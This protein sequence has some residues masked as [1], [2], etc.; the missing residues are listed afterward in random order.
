M[1]NIFKRKEERQNTPHEITMEER[2][3]EWDRKIER[4]NYKAR[5]EDREAER[6]EPIV[7]YKNT[8]SKQIRTPSED[9]R[10]AARRKKIKERD[11]QLLRELRETEQAGVD[12]LK[13]GGKVA[14]VMVKDVAA[15]GKVA[16]KGLSDWA[17]RMA[18]E[19]PKKKRA[20]PTTPKRKN[21][22]RTVKTV[23][24]TNKRTRT[25]T[26]KP[27]TVTKRKVVKKRKVTKRDN[28]IFW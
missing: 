25:S 20:K 8:P 26:R 9:E 15:A 6:N 21:V 28:D 27:V 10:I 19:P 3:R 14:K 1:F 7:Y 23:K 2:Q 17:D 18:E 5:E 22:K 11:E 24:P 13:K 12:A 4:E 16:W